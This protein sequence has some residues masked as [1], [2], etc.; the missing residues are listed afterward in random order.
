MKKSAIL[1]SVHFKTYKNKMMN[2]FESYNLMNLRIHTKAMVILNC[3]KN[4]TQNHQ[5]KI[6]AEYKHKEKIE[7]KSHQ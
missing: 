3:F 4:K 1:N 7:N 6:R 5:A 2:A